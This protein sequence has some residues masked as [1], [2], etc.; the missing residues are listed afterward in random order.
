MGWFGKSSSASTKE[1]RK[2]E[3]ELQK[4]TTAGSH[5][6][7]RAI[8]SNVSYIETSL[9]GCTDSIK[10]NEMGVAKVQLDKAAETVKEVNTALG[11]FEQTMMNA[12][13]SPKVAEKASKLFN[14]LHAIISQ[15][16]AQEKEIRTG[17]GW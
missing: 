15:L 10:N 7:L 1:S 17:K 6:A 5:E 11:Q 14:E 8:I 3:L 13:L 16:D 9:F 2:I 12:G 4:M